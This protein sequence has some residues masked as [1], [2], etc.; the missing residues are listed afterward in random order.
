MISL[1]RLTSIIA[2]IRAAGGGGGG[3]SEPL[4]GLTAATAL[5]AALNTVQS[6]CLSRCTTGLSMAHGCSMWKTQIAWKT[7]THHEA[8][9]NV[10]TEK[11]SEGIVSPLWR[12]R[13]KW[14]SWK[15]CSFVCVCCYRLL[16]LLYCVAVA[17]CWTGAEASKR[18]LSTFRWRLLKE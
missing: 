9:I 12:Q 3:G 16:L 11:P 15:R 4:R 14:G 2:A 5:S 13:Y 1:R 8:E 18:L 17:F 7:W 10:Y 6:L